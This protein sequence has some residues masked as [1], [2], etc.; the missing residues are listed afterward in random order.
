MRRLLAAIL[1]AIALVNAPLIG[2]P[3]QREVPPQN[4]SAGNPETRVWVNTK[5]GVYHCPSTRWY[6]STK[7]GDY[8]TQKEAQEKGYRPAYGKVCK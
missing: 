5:S 3:T 8:M 6:G 2:V 7:Q 1:L 4:Q